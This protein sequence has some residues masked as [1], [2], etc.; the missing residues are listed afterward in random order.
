MAFDAEQIR[1]TAQRVAASHGL[2][3]VELEFSGGAKHRLLRIF[4]EKNAEERKKLAEGTSMLETHI[5][6]PGMRGTQAEGT[7]MLEPMS[8]HQGHGAPETYIPTPGM[9]GTQAEGTSRSEPETHIPTAAGVDQLAGVTHTDCELFSRDF[10]TVLDVEDPIPGS[11]YTLEVSS[12]GLDR[13]LHGIEDY[14]RFAGMLAKVQTFEP[15]AGNRHWQGRLRE[16]D[17]GVVRL[18]VEGKKAGKKSAGLRAQGGGESE[19]EIAVSNIEK[20]QLVPEF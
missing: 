9:R 18:S 4:I 14:R 1:A 12:P 7:S 3:V 11:E 19:V 17:G 15:V 16:V 13:K 10:G 6:T 2:D 5:P 8:Q 20:A